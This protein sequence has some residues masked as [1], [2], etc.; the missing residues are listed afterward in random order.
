MSKIISRFFHKSIFLGIL[1]LWGGFLWAD[2]GEN[3]L[4]AGNNAFESESYTEAL[5][6]YEAA[7]EAGAYTEKSLYRLAFLQ[8]QLRN[9]SRAIFFLKKIQQDF[10][11]DLLEE[12]V[13]QLMQK[14]G[15]SHYLT[16]DFWPGYFRFFRNYGWIIW[17]LFLLSLAAL[18]GRIVVSR[19]KIPAWASSLTGVFAPIFAVSLITLTHYIFFTPDRAVIV[20]DTAFYSFPSYGA[21]FQ[22]GKLSPGETVDIVDSED[23]WVKVEAAEHAYWI[24][25]RTVERL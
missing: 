7:F 10:G 21:S 12:K 23:I 1:A 15:S 24:P 6:D 4:T 14:N 3:L 13:V 5:A 17:S 11:G 2:E 8:E 18:I 22:H 9:Y 16:S 19:D 25:A 20:Q